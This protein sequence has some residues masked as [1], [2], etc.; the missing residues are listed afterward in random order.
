MTWAISGQVGP[1]TRSGVDAHGW[2]WE[3]TSGDQERRVLVEVSGT[4]WAVNRNTLPEET[5]EAIRTEGRAE[6]EKVLSL[7]NPPRVVQCGTTG[8]RPLSDGDT[9]A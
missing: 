9:K 6:V 7:D 2:L 3:I 8:C 1:H 4:V 5:A